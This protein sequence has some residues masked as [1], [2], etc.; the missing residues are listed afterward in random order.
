[1]LSYFISKLRRSSWFAGA[2]IGVIILL[3]LIA[4]FI[5]FLQPVG[6]IDDE[7]VVFIISRGDSFKTIVKNLK[8]GGLIKSE[9][10]FKIY[11]LITGSAHLFKPGS[12]DLSPSTNGRDII[13]ALILGPQDIKVTIY[14]GE[15]LVDIDKRLSDAG[16]IGQKKLID[17]NEGRSQSLEGFLFPDT[18]YFAQSSSVEEI[19]E[20]LERNFQK[21][22]SQ[23]FNNNDYH[24]ILVIASLIEKEAIHPQDKLLV[25]GIIK[26][27]LEIGMPLQID[28]SL[29]YAKCKRAFLSCDDNIR[30]L[31]KEDLKTKS[32]YNT[33]LNSGLPPAPI[34]N[35]GKDSIIAALNPQK[36]KYLYYL[37]DPK[38]GR[39]IFSQTL[40]EHNRNRF[41]YLR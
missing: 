6:Q 28:A 1:M 12:Y 10:W 14:E 22:V 41:K 23:L 24:D 9:D 13:R 2:V 40:D 17:F 15:T 25:S 37:S 5:I 19:V 4:T 11:S 31:T 18:Y 34:S 26:K 33:Y 39:T 29:V 38:T 8:E 21:K 20:K 36:S 32:S 27:R 3:F 7:K 16:V 30:K 35:P